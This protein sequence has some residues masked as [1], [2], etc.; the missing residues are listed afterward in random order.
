MIMKYF[1]SFKINESFIS[2]I[3]RINFREDING[4]RALS[5]VS[6]V[7]YHLD[8]Q[9][10]KGGWLGVDIFFVISGY[11]I[12]NIIISD[13]NNKTF[14]FINF[15][16]RRILRILPALLFTLILT[17]PLAYFLLTPK[18]HY[19]F[20]SSLVST[21]LFYANLYFQNLDFYIA[22]STKLMPLLHTWS[23]AIEE[24]YYLVFPIFTFICF[25]FRKNYFF[26]ITTLFFITSIL[27]NSFTQE[28]TKFYQLQFRIWELLLGVIIMI[29]NSSYSFKHTEKIGL[30]LT[31]FSIFFFDDS[32]INDL[33]PKL[34]CLIGISLILISKNSTSFIS[35]ISK[36][37]LIS[38]TGLSS[39]SIY[40][41]HQPI[42]AFYNVIINNLEFY[43]YS[44]TFTDNA[45][46]NILDF[47]NSLKYSIDNPSIKLFLIFLLFTISLFSYYKIEKKFKNVKLVLTIYTLTLIFSY[48]M[49]NNPKTFNFGEEVSN[50]KSV[51]TD[52]TCLQ[53]ELRLTDPISKYSDCFYNPLAKEYLLILGDSSSAGLATNLLNSNITDKYGLLIVSGDYKVFFE[54]YKSND[55]CEN[56]IFNWMNEN[57]NKLTIIVSIELHRYIENQGIYFSE[58]YNLSK[59][60]INLLNNIKYFSENSNKLL[61]IEPFPTVPKN[62]INP[63]LF[64]S[65]KHKNSVEEVFIPLND[66]KQ[67][68]S[69]TAVFLEKLNNEIVNLDIVKTE[70]LFCNSKQNKCYIYK[71]P[72]LFYDDQTHLSIV[73]GKLLSDYF[74][75]KLNL[76]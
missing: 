9:M 39:Y 11:L 17:F 4:L 20:S 66:W 30:I 45:S 44:L 41:L 25:K 61:L 23:L 56:C 76:K 7:L 33:E 65:N 64:F 53:K 8:L 26:L 50:S 12:A 52:F 19:E 49:L 31:I 24:Q 68:T 37:K 71:K 5:V 29:L 28:T 14:S 59:E 67:N 15:Y 6:V 10:F 47:K 22:E 58:E 43:K 1:N 55:I 73:G 51:L 34:I 72:F 57:S 21:L 54:N 69:R 35:T 48:N 13:L 3:E 32:W 2:K 40:L 60:S 36:T 63:R 75:D 27:L 62:L 38:I 74:I 18:A 16:K 70:N 42:F 46:I